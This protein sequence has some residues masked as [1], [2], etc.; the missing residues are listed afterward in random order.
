MKKRT[1]IALASAA[2]IGTQ[3]ALITDEGTSTPAAGGIASHLVASG[4]EGNREVRWSSGT[5]HSLG[6][7]RFL[8]AS[9]GVAKGITLKIRS[10][11]TFSNWTANSFEIKVFEGVGATAT[12]LGSYAYDATAIASPTA[13]KWVRFGLDSGISMTS[14]T[15]Y[16]F[17]IVCGALDA[18]HRINFGRDSSSSGYSAGNELRGGNSYDIDNWDADPWDVSAPIGSTVNLAQTGDM[19]F[20][21]DTIPEPATLGLVAVF[22]GA[23]LFIRRRLSM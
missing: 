22:G 7:Q 3:A 13:G 21:V 16:S 11:E 4:T 17:M 6:G 14:G 23:V 18:D 10:V 19:L 20:S 5:A 15:E 9:T 12:E 8:A 1:L 2:A